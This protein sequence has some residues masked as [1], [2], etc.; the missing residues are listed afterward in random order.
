MSGNIDRWHGWECLF[1]ETRQTP[2]EQRLSFREAWGFCVFDKG[3]NLTEVFFLFFTAMT[4]MCLC[5][6]SGLSSHGFGAEEQF[7]LISDTAEM[8]QMLPVQL[9]H[10]PDSWCYT[11]LCS[12]FIIPSLLHEYSD[13][14]MRGAKSFRQSMRGICRVGT[15]QGSFMQAR[16][17][18]MQTCSV[19]FFICPSPLIGTCHFKTLYKQS[20]TKNNNQ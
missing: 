1:P 14:S 2:W 19:F 6:C 15:W 11:R 7:A 3:I 5:A 12:T 4:V 13:V 17:G 8:V 18:R 10:Q 9:L 16:E 20:W